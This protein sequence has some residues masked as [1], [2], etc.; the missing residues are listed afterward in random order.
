[1]ALEIYEY[2]E[3]PFQVSETS[4]ESKG[5]H[6]LQK[7]G[8]NQEEKPKDDTDIGNSDHHLDKRFSVVAENVGKLNALVATV[9]SPFLDEELVE[10]EKKLGQQEVD[11]E[12]KA[13]EEPF[14]QGYDVKQEDSAPTELHSHLDNYSPRN[15][16]LFL[17][18]KLQSLAKY[19]N[20]ME[21]IL[22]KSRTVALV[23]LYLEWTEFNKD[24]FSVTEKSSD[25]SE[26]HPEKWRGK[27]LKGARTGQQDENFEEPSNIKRG[28]ESL[29]ARK[30]LSRKAKSQAGKLMMEKDNKFRR[31]IVEEMEEMALLGSSNLIE[32]EMK[33]DISL[34]ADEDSD[35]DNE[36]DEPLVEETI[37]HG[38][39]ALQKEVTQKTPNPNSKSVTDENI[40]SPSAKRNS[41]TMKISTKKDS[42]RIGEKKLKHN[43][44][45]SNSLQIDEPILIKAKDSTDG[46]DE[47]KH[48]CEK[49]NGTGLNSYKIKIKKE[50]LDS[51]LDKN[52][53]GLLIDLVRKTMDPSDDKSLLAKRNTMLPIKQDQSLN[54]NS[55]VGLH[56]GKLSENNDNV[57]EI[58][59]INPSQSLTKKIL[60][61]FK[62]NKDKL[63]SGS[64]AKLAGECPAEQST[65]VPLK[66]LQLKVPII[67][68]TGGKA[69]VYSKQEMEKVT[70]LA[71]NVFNEIKRHNNSNVP[72]MTQMDTTLQD[73]KTSEEGNTKGMQIVKIKELSNY[74]STPGQSFIND[75]SELDIKKDQIVNDEESSSKTFSFDNS[76]MSKSEHLDQEVI[77]LPHHSGFKRFPLKSLKAVGK[78]SHN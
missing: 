47:V 10:T 64:L 78:N 57:I 77:S 65:S 9:C 8:K 43:L 12:F 34:W 46:Q 44:S 51:Y 29:P 28:Q 52:E 63:K 49:Q 30:S 72:P 54:K 76:V 2:T 26:H 7:G 56:A 16:H 35:D 45:S 55:T 41:R 48:P 40:V 61:S 73:F 23:K 3:K 25:L 66:V 58:K 18:T 21:N 53:P 39:A 32:E 27:R 70:K 5:E 37:W 60:N 33:W 15:E 4:N 14:N 69:K 11:E 74:N 6:N 75:R 19:L 59:E 42:L 36:S 50:D 13:N 17:A 68:E 71:L 62:Q 1:M 22:D 38:Y 24:G 31:E 20:P 67:K